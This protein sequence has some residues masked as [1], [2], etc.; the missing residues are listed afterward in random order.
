MLNFS[1]FKEASQLAKII[2]LSPRAHLSLDM[3]VIGLVIK[4]IFKI[5]NPAVT[6]R[7]QYNNLPIA[8]ELRDRMDLAVF[9]E[10]FIN[11][12]YV[13]QEQ[14]H[15]NIILD[16]GANIGTTSLFFANTYPDARIYSIEAD[17]DIYKRLLINTGGRPNITCFNLAISD[18]DGTLSFNKGVSHLGGS[19]KNRSSTVSTVSVPAKKLS[20]F[21]TEH[22]IQTVDLLKVDIE[23][24]EEEMFLDLANHPEIR[25]A[26]TMAELHYD[27]AD[28]QILENY[29]K[30]FTKSSV[31]P[32]GKDREL[33][34]GQF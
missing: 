21:L 1:I 28:R 5:P 15:P 17:P 24:A 14:I 18:T 11:K 34:Y 25:I 31:K 26:N 27:L 22:Q 6:I 2:E 7:G 12:E 16:I 19:I 23:G 32:L 8:F 20:S 13:L 30:R 33:F 10:V 29:K 4:K 9:K 3:F